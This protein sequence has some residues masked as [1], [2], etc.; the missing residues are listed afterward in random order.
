VE[1]NYLKSCA[2]D[3]SAST[4][5]ADVVDLMKTIEILDV[6]VSKLEAEK[7]RADVTIFRGSRQAISVSP[8]SEQDLVSTDSVEANTGAPLA[9]DDDVQSIAI[10]PSSSFEG[11]GCASAVTNPYTMRGRQIIHR[12]KSYDSQASVISTPFSVVDMRTRDAVMIRKTEVASPVSTVIHNAYSAPVDTSVLRT[13]S[14]DVSE[15]TSEHENPSGP[16]KIHRTKG[17]APTLLASDSFEANE[18]SSTNSVATI[19]ISNSYDKHDLVLERVDENG[20]EIPNNV[21][22]NCSNVLIDS[23]K[24]SNQR[25][26]SNPIFQSMRLLNK[27]KVSSRNKRQIPPPPIPPPPPPIDSDETSRKSS[28]QFSS[29][30]QEL[31]AF[32]ILEINGS[33]EVDEKSCE[34]HPPIHPEDQLCLDRLT[35]KR[36]MKS[37]SMLRHKPTSEKAEDALGSYRRFDRRNKRCSVVHEGDNE[38]ESNGAEC[39]QDS[40]D[41]SSADESSNSELLEDALSDA[42]IVTLPDMTAKEITVSYDLFCFAFF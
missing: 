1:Q 16:P 7:R 6:K 30:Q 25:R 20:P 8:I 42:A 19:K 38:E 31:D 40:I 17:H 3:G 22:I 11:R 21:G 14:S 24:E 34:S 12:N 10:H 15:S 2:S 36:R 27:L 29:Q 5:T 9:K 23:P 28:S 39:F 32:A 4:C 26:S 35:A 18:F 33:F 37:S 13:I 41:D